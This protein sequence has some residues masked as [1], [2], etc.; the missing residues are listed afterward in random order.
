V[1]QSQ[2]RI[3]ISELLRDSPVT[4]EKVLGDVRELLAAG[5]EGIAFDLLCSWIYEDSLPIS[6]NY[7]ER[8]AEIAEDM[9]AEAIVERLRELIALRGARKMSG[10]A[11]A[12]V[13]K[14]ACQ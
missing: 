14:L 5:E 12:A 3:I 6:A 13:R 2:Y 4:S 8:L 9:D 1:Y 7:H 11:C 10:L